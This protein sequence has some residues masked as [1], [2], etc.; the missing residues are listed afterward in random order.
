[1]PGIRLSNIFEQA[2]PILDGGNAIPFLPSTDASIVAKCVAPK[3]GR[4]RALTGR[5]IAPATAG[6][7][8]DHVQDVRVENGGYDGAGTT[9]VT[10]AVLVKDLTKTPDFLPVSGT[11]F[12]CLGLQ[13]AANT[14]KQG[15]I[16]HVVSRGSGTIGTGAR[17]SFVVEQV[18]YESPS[19]FDSLP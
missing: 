19:N 14:V 6:D 13:G 8:T 12:V 2:L 10:T 18:I 16:L 11:G 4:V 9:P 17:A 5:I 15:Q 1:M 7:S 3:N